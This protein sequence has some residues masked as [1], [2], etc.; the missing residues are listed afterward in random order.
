MV[1]LAALRSIRRLGWK[2]DGLPQDL[3]TSPFGR[4][5]WDAFAELSEKIDGACA[6][7]EARYYAFAGTFAKEETIINAWAA[8]VIDPLSLYRVVTAVALWCVPSMRA[9]ARQRGRHF[10]LDISLAPGMRDCLA[11][12]RLSRYGFAS[13][14]TVLG[15]PPCECEATIGPRS[16]SYRLTLP[17]SRTLMSRGRRRA[18]ELGDVVLTWLQQMQGEFTR[19]WQAGPHRG[20]AEPPSQWDLTPRERAVLTHLARGASNKE[21]AAHLG[22]ASRTVEVHVSR[23]LRKS[24][25]GGRSELIARLLG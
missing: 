9:S 22:C 4:V 12:F 10:Y 11:Y 14:V 5:S 25:A 8:A 19:V 23:I 1:P 6:G 17:P 20:Q 3:A 21:I 2:I 13:V 18:A 24:G 7:D 15:L 16:A